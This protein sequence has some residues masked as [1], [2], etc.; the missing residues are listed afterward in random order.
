MRCPQ[1]DSIIYK[2][3]KFCRFCG[4]IKQNDQSSSA[5]IWSDSIQ[6]GL[7]KEIHNGIGMKFALIPS[8]SFLMGTPNNAFQYRDDLPPHQVI[9]SKPFYLQTT[10]VTQGQWKNIMRNNPSHFN[11]S[12]FPE[13]ESDLWWEWEMQMKRKGQNLDELPVEMVSWDDTQKYIEKLNKIEATSKYRLPTEAEWE[14]SC[15]AGTVTKYYFGD[16][17]LRYKKYGWNMPI[18]EPVGQ[19]KPND[20]GLYDMH[21]N[22]WEW[23]SDWYGA[24][25]EHCVKDPV[26]P[27]S[28]EFRVLRGGPWHCYGQ[29]SEPFEADTDGSAARM[30]HWPFQKEKFFGFR[31]VRIL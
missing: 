26:G 20:W 5:Y 8:G 9:I 21:G 25:S 7:Q 10:A 2:Q 28:G 31:L 15:R 1:C 13:K 11:G 6:T 29:Y 27:K 24:Y 19:K 16:N 18:T 14:Y 4:W 30:K 12:E 23:C 17:A 3:E 22:V